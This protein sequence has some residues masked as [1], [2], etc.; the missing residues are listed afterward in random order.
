VCVSDGVAPDVHEAL[1]A[2]L[3]LALFDADALGSATA[4]LVDAASLE[5]NVMPVVI[6][7][8][9]SPEHVVNAIRAGAVDY[10]VRDAKGD[11]LNEIAS[12]F[13]ALLRA[14]PP[15]SPKTVAARFAQLL[16]TLHHDVKNPVHNI[17][18]FTELLLD[19]PGTKLTGEQAKFVGRIRENGNALLKILEE[20]GQAVDKMAA[21][22]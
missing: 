17:L 19:I 10:L 22:Q 4:D 20:F 1:G 15:H 12:K 18:G 8:D 21:G 2:G 14:G 11:Y 16:H 6:S 13:E 5:T 9:V 7:R 3:S